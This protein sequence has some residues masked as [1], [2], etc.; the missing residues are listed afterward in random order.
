[1]SLSGAVPLAGRSWP[2]PRP[3]CP[4]EPVIVDPA[5]LYPRATS[6]NAKE[7]P[8]VSTAKSVAGCHLVTLSHSILYGPEEVGESAMEIAYLTLYGLR[9]LISPV[10][11][12]GSWQTKSASST[13]STTDKNYCSAAYKQWVCD[14]AKRWRETRKRSV[15]EVGLSYTSST[16]T[17]LSKVALPSHGGDHEFESRR[18]HLE[19]DTE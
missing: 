15:A 6:R 13:S 17:R 14:R 12:S 11:L 5:Y 8:L 9:P 16:P 1:M 3:A 7:L 2:T 4:L 18:V 19:K 10:S